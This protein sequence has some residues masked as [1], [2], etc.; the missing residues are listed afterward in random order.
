MRVFLIQHGKTVPKAVDDREPLSEQGKIDA[1]TVADFFHSRQ[2]TAGEI[3]CSVK[4]RA[5]ETAQIIAEGIDMAH[6]KQRDGLNPLDPVKPIVTELEAMKHDIVIVGHLPFLERLMALLMCGD[7]KR[8]CAMFYPA[9]IVCLDRVQEGWNFSWFL[10]PAMLEKHDI[11]EDINI[12]SD[13]R[14]TSDA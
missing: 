4:P 8:P 5:V 7:E 12:L 3:W 10:T 11:V 2:I 9:G 1:R 14:F 13:K 6:L